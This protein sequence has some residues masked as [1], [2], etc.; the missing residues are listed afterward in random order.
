ME[1]AIEH[2]RLVEEAFSS[3]NIEL[4]L[5]DSSKA[6]L[7]NKPVR[8]YMTKQNNPTMRAVAVITSSGATR[9]AINLFLQ[10]FKPKY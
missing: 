7:M 5:A 4:S 10:F 3:F 1:D 2:T 8:D 6:G 9:I